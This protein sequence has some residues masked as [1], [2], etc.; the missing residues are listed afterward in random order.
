MSL[1]T[2]NFR[3]GTLALVKE[4]EQGKPKKPTSG[5]DFTAIQPDIALSPGLETLENEELKNSIMPGKSI[6]GRENPTISLS[7]YFRAGEDGQKPDYSLM[8]EA[9]F[10]SVSEVTVEP[11]IVAVTDKRTFEVDDAGEL[12][13]G[14]TLLVQSTTG[15]EPRPINSVVGNVVTLEFD[16]N[17]LPNVGALCGKPITYEPI[18]DSNL[19]PTLTSWYYLPNVIEMIAGTRI[20]GVDITFPAAELINATFSGSGI[21]FYYNPLVIEATNKFLDVEVGGQEYSASIPEGTYKDPEQVGEAVD[22][23][24]NANGSGL[25]YS[26]E[27]QKDGK[28]KIVADGSFIM[29]GATGSNVA[30]S[31]M[32]TI[33]FDAADTADATE[34]ESNN[35]IDLSS[36][37][38][39]QY[40]DSDPIAAKG[41]LLLI[42]DPEDNVCIHAS[43]VD[44]ALANTKAD[45]LDICAESGVGA[46]IFNERT[47]TA[48]VASYL[49]PYEAR[50]FAKLRKGDKVAFY[51][52]AGEKKGGQFIKDKC[53]AVYMSHATI[54]SLEISDQDGAAKLDLEIA[55]YAPED[56]TQSAFLGFV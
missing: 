41:N 5:N 52:C 23:A 27:Y 30:N 42:G 33:G 56:S 16:L 43:S 11:T 36:G 46:T 47:A 29:L 35:P 21:G 1:E 45:L 37:F 34:Q 22:N 4:D 7:H 28:Y 20:E 17:E 44:F 12:K 9:A 24:L 53:A 32:P 40:D 50:F 54:N 8:L 14:A 19:I 3:A 25:I 48:S 15:F 51:Y 49:Q 18:D 31:L 2:V 10:G 38:A 26:V 39:P 13:K 6:V 55:A